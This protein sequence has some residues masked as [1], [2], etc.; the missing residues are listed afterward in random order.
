MNRRFLDT[1]LMFTCF[2]MPL[3]VLLLFIP[4]F[5]SI[6]SG[7]SPLWLILILCPVMYIAMKSMHNH[8][9]HCS[10]KNMKK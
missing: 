10:T 7:T 4:Q 5:G 6:S 9:A 2:L 8:D 1:F 3:V